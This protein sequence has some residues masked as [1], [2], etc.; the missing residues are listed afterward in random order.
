MVSRGVLSEQ[1]VGFGARP[2]MV[3]VSYIG[4]LTTAFNREGGTLQE[5]T[6]AHATRP[7]FDS[8]GG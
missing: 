5:D 1:W 2:C 7:A 4:I 8:E 6:K 3:H